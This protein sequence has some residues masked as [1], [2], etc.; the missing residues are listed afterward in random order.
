MPTDEGMTILPFDTSSRPII[1]AARGGMGAMSATPRSDLPPP[2]L[3]VFRVKRHREDDA[4]DTLGS[5]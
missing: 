3:T 4:M 1:K 5:Q 2:K